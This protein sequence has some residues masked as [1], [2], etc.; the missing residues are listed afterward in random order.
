MNTHKIRNW[1]FIGIC[2]MAYIFFMYNVL[3]TAYLSFIG[4]HTASFLPA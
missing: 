3:A 1:L 4:K 2:F